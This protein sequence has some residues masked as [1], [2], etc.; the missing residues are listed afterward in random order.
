MAVICGNRSIGGDLDE[1]LEFDGLDGRG[2]TDDRQRSLPPFTIPGRVRHCHQVP[3]SAM[4]P[5]A[6]IAARMISTCAPQRHKLYR[7]AS[8][9]SASEGCGLRISNALV[10]MIMPFRQ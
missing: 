4:W 10:L 2:E 3:A 6:R 7:S 8:S 1:G 5:A 9:T